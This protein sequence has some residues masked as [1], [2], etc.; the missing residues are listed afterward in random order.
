MSVNLN[1]DVMD[2]CFTTYMAVYYDAKERGLINFVKKLFL[3]S[4]WD[5]GGSH[6][7]SRKYDM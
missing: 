2:M 6:K 7:A 1:G 5:T 3:N 4:S